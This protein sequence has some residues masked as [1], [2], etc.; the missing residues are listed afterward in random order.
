MMNSPTSISPASSDNEDID[1][2]IE[3]ILRENKEL[4]D[5]SKTVKEVSEGNSDKSPAEKVN[6]EQREL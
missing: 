3:S 5:L 4:E 1:S 2:C 6:D